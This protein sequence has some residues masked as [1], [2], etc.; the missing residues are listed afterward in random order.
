MK[1]VSISKAGNAWLQLGPEGMRQD[2]KAWRGGGAH[3]G[4][5]RCTGE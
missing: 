5:G 3:G 1:A 2:D 4:G